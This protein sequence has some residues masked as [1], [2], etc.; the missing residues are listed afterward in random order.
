MV[1]GHVSPLGFIFLGHI[2]HAWKK[3]VGEVQVQPP[4]VFEFIKNI[5]LS[6]GVNF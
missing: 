6:V 5:K 4:L 3:M 2:M 1:K